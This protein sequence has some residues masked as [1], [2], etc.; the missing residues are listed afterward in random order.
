MAQRYGMRPSAI[1]EIDDQVAALDFDLAVM[2]RA[3]K[4]END[5]VRNADSPRRRGSPA[6]AVRMLKEKFGHEVEH[7]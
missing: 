1:L 6:A 4:V 3:M 5:R 2:V 7:G